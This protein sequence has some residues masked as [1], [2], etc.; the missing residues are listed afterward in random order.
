MHSVAILNKIKL[1]V[2]IL[3][4]KCNVALSVDQGIIQKI[5]KCINGQQGVI[6]RWNLLKLQRCFILYCCLASSLQGSLCCVQVDI[7]LTDACVYLV[8]LSFEK[9]F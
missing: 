4:V 7:G 9:K 3:T 1:V 5:R 6:F 8:F 2:S